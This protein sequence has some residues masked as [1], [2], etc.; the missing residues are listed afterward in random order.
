MRVQMGIRV[1]SDQEDPRASANAEMLQ[2][3]WLDRELER[4][5]NVLGSTET[6]PAAWRN[7]PDA[8][9]T[10]EFLTPQEAKELSDEVHRIL[11]RYEDRQD[12]PSRRP[13]GA[14]PVE[15][16]FFSYPLID[17]AGL[18]EQTRQHDQGAGGYAR[19]SD[20]RSP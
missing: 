12:D 3:L 13:V 4:V 15:F 2:R 20:D 10:I 17:L 8:S 14:L 11:R 6:L 19:R 18:A 5:R 16:L 1:S 9:R 7:S